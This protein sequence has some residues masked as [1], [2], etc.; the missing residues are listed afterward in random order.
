MNRLSLRVS[1]LSFLFTLLCF[2]KSNAQSPANTI[3]SVLRKW[4]QEEVN[5]A[6][7]AASIAELTNVEKETILYVNLARLYPKKFAKAEVETYYGNAYYGDYV[8][9][10]D[11]RHSLIKTLNTMKSTNALVFDEGAYE[12]AKCFAKE[13][14]D[15]GIT[16]HQRINCKKGNY[17]ECCSYGMDNGREIALQWLIDH[18]VASLGHRINCLNPAYT[19]IAVSFHTHTKYRICAVA[20]MIW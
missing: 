8:K 14:G 19:K 4:T 5:A 13:S 17:A 20:D 3:D 2:A 18:N 16:G 12:N 1:L 15:N 10:S 9:N 6:N 11:Y 7:T